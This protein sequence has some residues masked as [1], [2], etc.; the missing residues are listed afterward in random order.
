MSKISEDLGLTKDRIVLM[1]IFLGCDF[2]PS[3]VPGVGKETVLALFRSWKKEWDALEMMSFWIE[4]KF[5]AS[6]CWKCNH[7]SHCSRCERWNE[8]VRSGGGCLC[9]PM[10]DKKVAKVDALIKKRCQ[11]VAQTFWTEDYPKIVDEFVKE[12][13]VPDIDACLKRNCPKIGHCMSILV[14][15]LA[16]TEEYAQE[17]MLP[18]LTRWQL[19]HLVQGGVSQVIRPEAIAK[20]RTVNGVASLAMK[21]VINDEVKEDIAELPKTF[22]SVEPFSLVEAAYPEMCADFI[23]STMPKKAPK[24]TSSQ[25]QRKT[26]PKN[27]MPSQCS[28]AQKPITQYF[29][30]QDKAP[31]RD[32]TVSDF[33]DE[34]VSDLSSIIDDILAKKVHNMTVEMEEPSSCLVTSTPSTSRQKSRLDSSTGNNT[35][36]MDDVDGRQS[37][38]VKSIFAHKNVFSE[39]VDEL[40]DT[41]DRMCK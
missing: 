28:Q 34:E 39:S 36:E 17:R 3:G 11:A 23:A 21:W 27:H 18:L 35:V 15:K 25:R 29:S 30:T 37:P 20:K 14:K 40:E 4:T 16:W 12:R 1:A 19:E 9:E 41:F 13:P 10:K 8:V 31:S 32:E 5:E 33:S 2:F 7:F 24:K 38:V 22:E 6:D 26:N